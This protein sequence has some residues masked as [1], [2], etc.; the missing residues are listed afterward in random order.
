LGHLLRGEAEYVF[1][2]RVLMRVY[3]DVKERMN[4]SN[5]RQVVHYFH[6]SCYLSHFLS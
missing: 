4:E 6:P 3:D 2:N 1:L 5:L